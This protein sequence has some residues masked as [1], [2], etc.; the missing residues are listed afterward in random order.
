LKLRLSGISAALTVVLFALVVA[1]GGTAEAAPDKTCFS[2]MSDEDKQALRE[3][4]DSH[5]DD[6]ENRGQND[7]GSKSVCVIEH[8]AD[9]SY[10]EHH[11]RDEKED[12]FS[13][14]LLYSMLLGDSRNIA[15]VGL[16]NGDLSLTDY[17]ALRY[18]TGVDD[19][20][21]TYSMYGCSGYRGD[22][23]N[24]R[25]NETKVINQTVKV[26]H[27]QYGSAPALDFKDAKGRKPPEGY[28]STTAKPVTTPSTERHARVKIQ[29]GGLGVPG[30]KK[31]GTQTSV[32]AKQTTSQTPPPPVASTPRPVPP[33][34]T[35]TAKPAPQTTTKSTQKKVTP[36]AKKTG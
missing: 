9:G 18:L 14:Y 5:G 32:S 6:T 16:I 10:E 2:Q 11:Y 13:D 19:D 15:N 20:G 22:R 21:G 27:I 36:T 31:S 3:Y 26:T 29:R 33:E 7:D 28:G 24:C 23:P 1:C 8:A 17:M 4:A 35:T 34:Q 12:H 25:R 30:D